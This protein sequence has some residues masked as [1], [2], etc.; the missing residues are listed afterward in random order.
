M[1]QEHAQIGVHVLNRHINDQSRTTL[2]PLFCKIA[3]DLSAV[4]AT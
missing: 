4:T 3:I 1:T 2:I